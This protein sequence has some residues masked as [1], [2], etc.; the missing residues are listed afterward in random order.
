MDWWLGLVIV[1][2]FVLG[3][4]VYRMSFPNPFPNKRI[5]ITGANSGVGKRL[6]QKLVGE[7]CV[8]LLL[9]GKNLEGLEILGSLNYK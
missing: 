7:Q 6:A 3:Q 8:E 1:V 2:F 5:L 4:K 9:L